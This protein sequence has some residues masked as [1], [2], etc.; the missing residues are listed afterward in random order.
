[1]LAL[2]DPLTDARMSIGA[3][4]GHMLRVGVVL[5][6]GAEPFTSARVLIVGDLVRRVLEDVHSVQVLAAVITDDHAA[7]LRGLRPDFMVRPVVGVFGTRAL[8][9]TEVGK[10]LDLLITAGEPAQDAGPRVPSV[11]VGA[12]TS[13]VQYETYDSATVRFALAKAAYAHPVEVTSP[14]LEDCHAVLQR[15]RNRIDQWS[16]NPSR[17]I[18]ADWRAAVIA[19]LD[20]NL[21]VANVVAMMGELESA[22]GIEP[23]AKF[24]AFT[25]TDRVLAVDL[26]RALCRPPR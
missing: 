17:P 26:T 9:E 16:R 13:A 1:M 8:A 7:A 15:W 23:G 5:P 10:P 21:D 19:A 22:K 11:G 25:Y 24:E 2:N 6:A 4:P 20:D 12:V 3:A 14:L 18:P